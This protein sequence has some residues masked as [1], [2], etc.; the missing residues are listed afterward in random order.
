AYRMFDELKTMIRRDVART[1]YRVTVVRQP[2]TGPAARMFES[3]PDVNGS[4]SATAPATAGVV[5]TAGAAAGGRQPVRAGTKIGRNDPCYCG[6][7]KKY[8]R[9][10]GA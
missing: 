10:H 9:C 4:G 8:K 5:A 3:R 1:I 6:S 7:G 2:A